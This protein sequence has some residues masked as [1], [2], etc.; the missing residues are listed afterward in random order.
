[1]YLEFL[2]NAA[3]NAIAAKDIKV[4]ARAWDLAVA[5]LGSEQAVKNNMAPS[6]NMLAPETPNG[7]DVVMMPDVMSGLWIAEYCLENNVPASAV[8]WDY[9]SA[10]AGRIAQTA[11]MAW[12]ARGQKPSQLPPIVG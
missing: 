1:M 12:T 4:Y 10:M 9:F 3:T 7:M 5:N 2:T 8:T 6:P 11:I